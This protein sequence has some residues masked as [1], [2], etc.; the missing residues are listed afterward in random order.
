[1]STRTTDD[2][3]PRD[4]SV[5]CWDTPDIYL[6]DDV[7]LVILT[8]TRDDTVAAMRTSDVLV[9]DADHAAPREGDGWDRLGAL[10]ELADA[11]QGCAVVMVV[12][13]PAAEADGLEGDWGDAEE[14][15]RAGATEVIRSGADRAEVMRV[16]RS[17]HAR[18]QLARRRLRSHDENVRVRDGVIGA[19]GS[20]TSRTP[21]SAR[22]YG[23]PGASDVDEVT[24]AALVHRYRRLVQ[25]RLDERRSTVDLAFAHQA[26]ELALEVAALDLG[27]RDVATLHREALAPLLHTAAPERARAVVAAGETLLIAVLGHLADRYRVQGRGVQTLRPPA[28]LADQGT[29]PEDDLGLEVPG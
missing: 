6:P 11:G 14:A 13:P 10:A 16:L 5:V 24:R 19:M 17:A 27:A 1:M 2:P 7:T 26:R 22:R 28:D 21:A 4:I 3:R 20:Q 15:L 23:I 29:S 18:G 25:V 8:S 9:V 12:D